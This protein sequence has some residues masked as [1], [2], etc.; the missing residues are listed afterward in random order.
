MEYFDFELRIGAG[1]DFEYPVAVVRSPMGE[2]SATIRIPIDESD[3]IRD[4][5]ILE[6]VRGPVDETRTARPLDRHLGATDLTS[7][8]ESTVGREI[9]LKLFDALFLPEIR[10]SYRS[11]LAASRKD[12]K[13][14]RLR[15]RIEAPELAALP[16]EFLFDAT[17]GDHICLNRETPLT[18]YLELNRPTPPLKVQPPIRILGMVA[19]PRDLPLLDTALEKQRIANAVEHL[20]E[21]GDVQV[22]W[23]RGETWQDLQAELANGPWHVFHFIGHGSFDRNK[24]E[25]HV[26]FSDER[27]QANSISATQLGRLFCRTSLIASSYHQRL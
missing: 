23:V 26:L 20:Q 13:G 2:V 8:D 5:E 3:F 12:G 17:E 4:L 11:S 25:G 18:R 9:G 24:G 10:S 22:T 16:W 1:K 27:G 19:S 6:T 14:L 7:A 21:R 15:L